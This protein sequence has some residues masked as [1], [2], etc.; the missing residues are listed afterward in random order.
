MESVTWRRASVL[1]V[2][3]ENPAAHS[4]VLDIA[5]WPGHRPGQHLDVRL[6]AE[7]GYQAS[8]SY[9]IATPAAGSHVTLTVVR[10]PNG[11]VSPYLVDE[12][13]PGDQFE[14]RGP[15][16]GYFVWEA[17]QGG[18]LLLVA[19]G[20]GAVPLMCMLRGRA[21]AGSQVPTTLLYSL[22]D[23]EAGLY[24][25]ELRAMAANDPAFTLTLTYTRTAPAGWRGRTGRVDAQMIADAAP[26]GRPE[27]LSYVCGPTP[28]V[29]AVAGELVALGFAPLKV[30]TERFGP[31]GG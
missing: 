28:F 9:S 31:T 1:E 29:E 12:A 17:G 4:L 10:V 5:G 14:V 30:K 7:G 13:R 19:G 21:E 2:R 3:P 25:A 24:L 20:S 8:R 11:E 26:S 22:R 18:P 23:E 16:G 27:L 6:T 15:I